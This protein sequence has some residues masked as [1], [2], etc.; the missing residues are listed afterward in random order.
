MTRRIITG[1]ILFC[2]TIYTLWFTPDI[3]FLTLSTVIMVLAAWEWAAIVPL[4]TLL[5]RLSYVCGFVIFLALLYFQFIPVLLWLWF[6]LV[7]AAWAVYKLYDYSVN[8]SPIHVKGRHRLGRV[9]MGW[10]LLSALWLSINLMRFSPFSPNWL[11]FAFV[12]VW[13]TDTG[14]YFVGKRW[15]RRK[16][17]PHVS[18]NKTWE[19]LLGGTVSALVLGVC[20]LYLLPIPFKTISFSRIFIIILLVSVVSVLGDLFE[21]VL[22]REVQKKDSGHWLPGHGGFLDRLDSLMFALPLYALISFYYLLA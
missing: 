19:G 7:L 4:E 2:F 12:I 10:L 1:L 14:A 21:S 13:S 11:F 22:K 18:P 17:S 16:L 8:P 5:A 6:N 9:C 20:F 15:G 3:L